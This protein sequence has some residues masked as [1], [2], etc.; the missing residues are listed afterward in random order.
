VIA[1]SL[2]IS[3]MDKKPVVLT[4]FSNAVVFVTT[5]KSVQKIIGLLG[6]PNI[7]SFVTTEDPDED[8][9]HLHYEE[10]GICFRFKHEQLPES[11]NFLAWLEHDK[12]KTSIAGSVNF[13]KPDGSF[14]QFCNADWLEL[15]IEHVDIT[16]FTM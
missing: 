13:R 10:H 3:Q 2:V 11:G 5:S 4:N 16:F 6:H 9:A 15:R 14:L 12:G 1:R 8:I 7:M